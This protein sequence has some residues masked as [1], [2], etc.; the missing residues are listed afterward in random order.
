[1]S[2][3]DN[4]GP[5]YWHIKS[6]TIQREPP[7]WPKEQTKELR[8]PVLPPP[9]INQY[10]QHQTSR[11]IKS[12]FSSTLSSIYG[13]RDVLGGKVSGKTKEN[14]HNFFRNTTKIKTV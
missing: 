10:Y 9:N 4:E 8:T 7:L 6:G 11:E 2:L 1:M 5:Y 14:Y 3:T 12:S 13:N